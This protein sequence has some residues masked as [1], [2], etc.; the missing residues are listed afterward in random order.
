MKLFIVLLFTVA[1]SYAAFPSQPEVRCLFQKA[2]TGENACRTLVRML[3]PYNETNNPLLGG[4]KACGTMMMAKY[5]LNPFTKLSY[6]L[7]GRSILE[8][9]I[10]ADAENIELR[11]LRYTIQKKAP[12]F[13]N[14]RSSV[15]EDKRIITG[16][17]AGIKD[18]GLKKMIIDFLR[19]DKS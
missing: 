3:A 12:F 11:F 14:Y 18:T 1:S 15:N 4:Y 10:A 13:L 2:A 6:F 16:T 19:S 5:V 17:V 7:K 8:K 9:C